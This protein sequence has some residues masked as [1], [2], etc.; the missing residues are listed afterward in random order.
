MSFRRPVRSLTHRLPLPLA[1]ATDEG[2]AKCCSPG[3]MS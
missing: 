2:K 3:W 1:S